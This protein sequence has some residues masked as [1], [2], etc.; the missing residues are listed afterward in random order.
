ML[1]TTGDVSSA[2]T[3]TADIFDL[4]QIK[5]LDYNEYSQLI[6]YTFVRTTT[7]SEDVGVADNNQMCYEYIDKYTNKT[8]TF[9][10]RIKTIQDYK[11][12]LLLV[13]L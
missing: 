7:Q 2:P 3:G 11:G 4:K 6:R 9:Y 10:K 12:Y 8:V 1:S 13:T 5:I